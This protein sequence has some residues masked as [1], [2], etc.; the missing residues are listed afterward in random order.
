MGRDEVVAFQSEHGIEFWPV[1]EV[2]SLTPEFRGR[3]RGVMRDGTVLHRPEP[4]DTRFWARLGPSWVTPALL[5]SEGKDPAGF[6]HRGEAVAPVSPLPEPWPPIDGLPC[7]PERVFGLE[8]EGPRSCVWRTEVGDVRWDHENAA[9]AARHHPGLVKLTDGCYVRR[10]ALR[11]MVARGRGWDVI[12]ADGSP[13]ATLSRE[14]KGA[15]ERLGLPHLRH[16]EPHFPAMYRECLRDYPFEL[17]TCK[18]LRGL[19]RSPRHAIVNVIYQALRFPKPGIYGTSYRGFYY[20][21]IVPILHRAGFLTRRSLVSK[22][23]PLYQDVLER[24]V[25]DDRLFTYRELGFADANAA[26]R[27]VGPTR[28]E[29]VLVIEKES[30]LEAAQQMAAEFGVSFIVTGGSPKLLDVE[31]FAPDLPIEVDV[32]AV[33]DYDPPGWGIGRACCGQLERSGVRVRRLHYLVQRE[34]FSAT[35]VELYALPCSPGKQTADWVRESGGIDGAALGIHIDH[36][37][38]VERFGKLLEAWLHA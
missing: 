24:L 2:A 3:W 22:H 8:A 38:P 12:L 9:A 14:A 34:A 26:M 37:K 17:A 4:P 7:A 29:V 18:E 16:L 19:F 1:N 10:G 36:V 13:F 20:D 15:A 35:E 32:V 11:R 33:V 6:L 28:P 30:L 25:G 23:Y 21:P 31:Y 27:R 5:D